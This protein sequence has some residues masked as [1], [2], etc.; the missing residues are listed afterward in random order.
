MLPALADA[1]RL[2]CQV[3]V[4]LWNAQ[5]T[6]CIKKFDS[7][8]AAAHEVGVNSFEVK[9]AAEYNS[10]IEGK[11]VDWPDYASTHAPLVPA[12]FK[13]EAQARLSLGP[14]SPACHPACFSYAPGH[15]A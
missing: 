4:E 9:E 11:R 13:G 15:C 6:Q 2:R 7:Y 3:E 1:V 8:E 12:L 14:L 10:I 5:K